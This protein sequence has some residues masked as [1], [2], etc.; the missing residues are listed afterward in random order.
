MDCA[1][2]RSVASVCKLPPKLCRNSRPVPFK[3]RAGLTKGETMKVKTSV[4]ASVLASLVV[5]SSMLS[6]PTSAQTRYI[7]SPSK[8]Y[9]STGGVQDKFFPD[10][11]VEF[12]IPLNAYNWFAYTTTTGTESRV[13]AFSTTAQV[14]FRNGKKV[15]RVTTGYRA[16]HCS[17]SI[18]PLTWGCNYTG[19]IQQWASVLRLRYYA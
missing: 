11:V 19:S 2:F 16:R 9:V 1:K 3:S 6:F 14:G 12:D 4:I 7:A 8:Y 15:I 13:L 5:A 18:N 10:Y 17:D